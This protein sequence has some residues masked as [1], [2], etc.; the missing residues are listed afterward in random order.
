MPIFELYSTRNK[1]IYPDIY[2]Y[3]LPSKKLRVQISKIIGDGIG[4]Y[5]QYRNGLSK[6]YSCSLFLFQDAFDLLTKEYGVEESHN[7]SSGSYRWAKK[8]I[9][10]EHNVEYFLDAI[11]LFCTLML[12]KVQNKFYDF[13][14]EGGAIQCAED[15]VDEINER[16][17]RDGFGYEYIDG[18]IV[19]VDQ[20]FI[21][22]EVTKPALFLLSE[23][24]GARQ[25]FLNAHEHYRHN[26][27]LIHI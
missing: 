10:D 15:A 22:S 19:R 17:K 16:M 7:H 9:T 6:P 23:F 5:E 14:N 3:N 26:L 18:I 25:E 11:E 8:L 13:K 1:N 21:H 24:D 20:G 27:S 4:I 12:T 2:Q